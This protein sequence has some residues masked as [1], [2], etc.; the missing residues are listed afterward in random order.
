MIGAVASTATSSKYCERSEPSVLGTA[1]TSQSLL[2]SCPAPLCADISGAKVA[3]LRSH[4][5]LTA[6]WAAPSCQAGLEGLSYRHRKVQLVC[7]VTKSESM[8]PGAQDGTEK[9]GRIPVPVC[10]LL[11]LMLKQR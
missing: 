6:A 7:K 11:T 3:F 9:S 2:C 8:K 4:L 1:F 10:V 5:F